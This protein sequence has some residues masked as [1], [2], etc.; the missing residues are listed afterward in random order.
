M[1]KELDFGQPEFTLAKLGI[2][3]M[4]SELSQYQME[5]LPMFFL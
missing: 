1:P 3:L 2:Q 5:M 4:F